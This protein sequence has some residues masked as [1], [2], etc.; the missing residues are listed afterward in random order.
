MTKLVRFDWAIKFL[1][2]NKA[3]YD[4]LE[5][6]LS[7]LLKTD[8]KIE[9]IL[10]SES[11]KTTADDKFNRVDLL[12]QAGKQEHIIIEVQCSSQWDY[13]SRILYGTSKT[14]TEHLHEGES[15]HHV[16]K[17]ISVSIV[18]FN[19][20]EGKDYLY[21]GATE[22]RGMH[23]QDELKLGQ[24][25]MKIY[26]Q[27]QTPTAIF[28]EYYIIKVNQFN[29]RIQDKF[30]EWVYFLKN[31][32][33]QPGFNARGIQSAAEKLDVLKL[34]AEKRR[35][36]ER[37]QET[38]HYDASMA[39]PYE[40]GKAEGREEGTKQMQLQI[41]KKLLTEGMKATFITQITGLSVAEIE[42][43]DG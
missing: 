38:L 4:I 33:I 17:V 35:A 11:N 26:G 37:Y 22:F 3:N 36:Y 39:L 18:F 21:K 29:E 7:E 31:D 42:T 32:Q 8:I 15:Y 2:R 34:S 20:G 14:I 19:L 43:L 24:E 10:D 12:V 1:L 27:E 25:E 16:R 30:D 6:F 9:S 28:P 23:Y 41:A 5:G 40:I 13:L